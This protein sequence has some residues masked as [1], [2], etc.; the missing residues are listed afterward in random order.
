MFILLLFAYIRIAVVCFVTETFRM[1]VSIVDTNTCQCGFAKLNHSVVES[2][3]KVQIVIY[4]QV[5]L[6]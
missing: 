4:S 3:N 1:C 5:S 2:V 6:R